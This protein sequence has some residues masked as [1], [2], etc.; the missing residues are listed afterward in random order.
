MATKEE[1]IR[2]LNEDVHQR[3]RPTTTKPPGGP[4]GQRPDRGKPTTDIDTKE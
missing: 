1:L 2:P 4:G 3:P